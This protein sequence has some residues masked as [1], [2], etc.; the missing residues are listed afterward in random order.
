MKTNTTVVPADNIAR[1]M[2]YLNSVNNCVDIQIDDRLMNFRNF[3]LLTELEKRD[4]VTCAHRYRPGALGGIIF[5]EVE[6]SSYLLTDTSNNFLAL[7][8]P[9]VIGSFNLNSNVVVVDGVQS[10]IRR[11]MIFKRA[12]MASYY[13]IPFDEE[14]WRIGLGP[15]PV[16]V[17]G[18]RRT[19]HKTHS[20]QDVPFWCMGG[21]LCCLILPPVGLALLCVAACRAGE[22]A[23]RN[24]DDSV[25]TTAYVVY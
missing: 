12:W 3:H 20:G 15:Q 24:R 4:V 17:V 18:V 23:S 11:V 5:F 2:Y 13:S 10:I 14:K 8:D 6:N 16:T 7:D 19:H 22:E 9:V 25:E 1:L 21:L